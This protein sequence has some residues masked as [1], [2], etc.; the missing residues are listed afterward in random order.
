MCIRDSDYI[1]KTI[2]KNGNFVIPTKEEME[3]LADEGYRPNG[4]YFY[5]I[6]NGKQKKI[7]PLYENYQQLLNC[8]AMVSII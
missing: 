7:G 8:S 4:F 2:D 3:K 1:L 6:E 5:M